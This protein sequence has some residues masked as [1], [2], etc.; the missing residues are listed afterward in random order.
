MDDMCVDRI[1][2]TVVASVVIMDRRVVVDD[3]G[4]KIGRTALVL[5]AAKDRTGS[6]HMLRFSVILATCCEHSLL[7]PL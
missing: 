1:V 4:F 7:A 5:A 3:V 2:V 6:N